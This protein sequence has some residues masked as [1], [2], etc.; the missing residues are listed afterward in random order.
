MSKKREKLPCGCVL[1]DSGTI[2]RCKD[3]E[4]STE[5]E[6]LDQAFEDLME[7]LGG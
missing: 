3:H 2:K 4:N 7:K 5:D 1:D 6:V